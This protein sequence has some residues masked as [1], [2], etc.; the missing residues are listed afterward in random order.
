MTLKT[1]DLAICTEVSQFTIRDYSDQGLLG[2]IL[3][4]KSSS[5]RSYDP[6]QIPHVYLIRK[7][8]EMGLTT[9][10]LKEFAQNRSPEEALEL[11]RRCCK[12]LQNKIMEL[13]APLNMLQSYMSLIEE[14][15]S[16]MPGTIAI[17][18]LPEQPIRRSALEYQ[19]GTARSLEQLR[20]AHGE[21]R[22]NGNPGCPMGFEYNAFSNLIEAPEQPAQLVSYDPLGP[23]IR[24]AG[25]YLVGA[26]HCYYS[27]K[28]G[29]AR[30]MSDYAAHNGLELYGPVSAVYLHDAASVAEPEKYLLQISAKVDRTARDT[31][32]ENGEAKEHSTNLPQGWKTGYFYG[33]F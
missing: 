6:R 12:D 20:R 31:L 24:P 28:N 16:V 29:L 23:D 5:Y 22:Q 14:G 32:D 11:F 30:R 4:T 8:R 18:Q 25:E 7:L 26:V 17:R 1:S 13:Q 21:I 15:K 2:P 10:Q 3:R 9:Q 27:Q 19:N 33:G